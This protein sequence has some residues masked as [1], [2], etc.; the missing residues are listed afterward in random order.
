MTEPII[1]LSAAACAMQ[2]GLTVRA[3]RV[4]ENHGLIKP[5]RSPAGWRRYGTRELLRLN[6]ITLLKVL[7]L[8]LSQIKDLLIRPS[9]PSLEQLLR[10]QLG[11]WRERRRQAERGEAVTEAA[12]QHL[13]SSG[14]VQVE[15]LCNLIRSIDMKTLAPDAEL[16][17]AEESVPAN[18]ALDRYVGHYLRN[19][20][21][22]AISITRHNDTLILTPAGKPGVTLEQTGESDFMLPELDLVLCFEQVEEGA[23][24]QLVVWFPGMSIR[25]HRTDESTAAIAN[26]ALE[27]RVREG[28]PMP[29]SADALRRLLDGFRAGA[30]EYDAMSP[31]LA[32][33]ARGQSL[34]WQVA[35]QYFG[36]ILSMEFVCV[37]P[38][39]WDIYQVQHENDVHRY[40]LAMGDDGKVLGFT[41]ASATAERRSLV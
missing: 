10:L 36:A 8:T 22:G 35:G 14:R 25:L 2:T 38:S 33:I 40:R 18:A 13:Q 3:L 30:A 29:G 26:H 32:E 24:Q 5:D 37:S 12:L 19:R 4:Y 17:A 41:E 6:Q 20:K 39:G 28:R 31:Q 23:A 16:P 34:A 15:A 27:E 21:L 9:A 1:E 11:S 7:G